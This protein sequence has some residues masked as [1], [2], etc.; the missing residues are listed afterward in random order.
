MKKVSKP[1]KP[2]LKL[3]FGPRLIGS[4]VSEPNVFRFGVAVLPEYEVAGH[5]GGTPL[6]GAR[7]CGK[8][9]A[10]HQ[11][12]QLSAG[13]Y[14]VCTGGGGS[15]RNQLWTIVNRTWLTAG[16]EKGR[17]REPSR[18]FQKCQASRRKGFARSVNSGA[19]STRYCRPITQVRPD[20]RL[21]F[22][23]DSL[24]GCKRAVMGP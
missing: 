15:R 20:L 13:L 1:Q 3:Y 10:Q 8:C 6:G 16:V 5:S 23:M 14:P 18:N 24:P 7:L 19:R 21:S 11:R 12:G 2:S 4:T 17:R 22:S 9:A